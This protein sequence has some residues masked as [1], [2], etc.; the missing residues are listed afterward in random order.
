MK[1][2]LRSLRSFAVNS[3]WLD[4]VETPCFVV[5]EDKLK[6]NLAV[7]DTVQKRTGCTIL[8]ALKG[9]AM[10]RVFPLI[11]Q[12]LRG[13]CASGLHEARLGR[14]EFGGEV[15]V[16][17]PAYSAADLAELVKIADHLVFNSFSQWHLARDIIAKSGRDISAGLRVN[18]EHSEAK[19]EMYDPCARYSRLGIRFTE[20]EEQD[21][22]G[23]SGLHLHVLC[24]QNADALVR[25]LVSFEDRFEKYIPKMKWIN[26][27]GGH[28][29]TRDDYDV[30][31]LCDLITRFREKYGVQVYLEPGEAIALNAGVLVSTVMD[32]KRNEKH[33]AILDTS[34]TTHMPDVLE[35]P[36]RP[37]IRGAEKPDHFDYNF[38]LGGP[39]CLAGDVIGDYSFEKP[40]QPGDRLVFEDMAHYT[41]VKTTTFNGVPLPSIYLCAS[42]N[43]EPELVRKFGY[44]DFKSR[45]S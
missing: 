13:V 40:L 25:T 34:A 21:L 12:T 22:T 26:F 23:I 4:K 11:R 29:I 9:F 24:E 39:S 45:L 44:E 6:A 35:M 20:F 36:Y 10:F 31:L 38:R 16:F 2:S 28:H 33:I 43:A 15:H 18:P 14:E 1:E 42:E 32:I 5:F 41:M 3:P 8:M 17:S 27:G 30:D 37:A 7:L 19:V